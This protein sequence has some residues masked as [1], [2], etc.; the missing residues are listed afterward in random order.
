MR[1]SLKKPQ[2]VAVHETAA[3]PTPARLQQTLTV[4]PQEQKLAILWS[5]LKT[6]LR[7]R[8]LIFL[9]SCKQ[10]KFVYESFRKLRPGLPLR[11]L[12][13]KMKQSKRMQVFYSFCE[14]AQPTALFATDVAARGLDFPNVDW[15]RSSLHPPESSMNN[16]RSTS[17]LRC[18]MDVNSNMNSVVNNSIV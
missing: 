13:G 11:C 3:A 10:V 9:A 14:K 15:V 4:I 17:N 7:S 2:Y 5:F 18:K 12:H 8:T 16:S 1:L 6:H